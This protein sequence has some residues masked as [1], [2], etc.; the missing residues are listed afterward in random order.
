[1]GS[2]S[3]GGPGHLCQRSYVAARE[4]SHQGLQPHTVILGL[5]RPMEVRSACWTHKCFG[6]MDCA[7][8]QAHTCIHIDFQPG[9]MRIDRYSPYQA[10]EL[11]PGMIL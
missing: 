10:S 6:W 8:A 7:K 1:M 5:K 9:L 4:S 2:A 11:A 3:K